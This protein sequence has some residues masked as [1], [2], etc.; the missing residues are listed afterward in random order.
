MTDESNE[1][2]APPPKL[3]IGQRMLT[4]LP[5]LQ[6]RRDTAADA[7]AGEGVD[8]GPG[9]AT[10]TEDGGATSTETSDAPATA[11]SAARDRGA[12]APAGAARGVNPYTEW[13]REK[14]SHAMKYLDP[15]ERRLALMAG[16]L[17][18][19][20]NVTLTFV[21]L[22]N[23]HRVVNGQLNKSYENP[24]TI[25]A[26]GIGSAVVAG[27]VVVSGI[28]RRRSFTIFALL[29]AGYGGGPV[30]LLPSWALAGWLFVRFNRM[31]KALRMKDGGARA[32]ARSRGASKS[33]V[34]SSPRAA[35]RAGV[36]AGRDRRSG[37]RTRGRNVP[38]PAGPGASKRYTPP[39][40]PRPRPP[41][42]PS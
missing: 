8:A 15:R 17:L 5:N 37:S 11:R 27:V 29:F 32:Q 36:A 41:A 23:N 26:L 30:T 10:T 25:I 1:R 24:S 38:V 39:K 35:A 16:P 4:V 20:L 21:T 12:R 22:H 33:R 19:A 9:D 31:Q 28:F 7:D 3:T 40:P 14:I 2:D 42:P 18:I 13:P 34:P 6:A